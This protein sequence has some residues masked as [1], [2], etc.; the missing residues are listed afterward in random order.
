MPRRVGDD[1]SAPRRRKKT[2]GD[3]DR[4][5]L[6]ALVF[7]PIEQQRE[8]DVAAG[9]AETPRLAFECFELVGQNQFG[10][11]EQPADQGRFAV[12]DRSAGQE[13]QQ[14]SVGRHRHSDSV[15]RHQK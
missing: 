8:I 7:E 9:R 14:P 13:A 10:V 15:I 4:D 6:L 3:I 12:I 5:A 2:V 1:K 11:V